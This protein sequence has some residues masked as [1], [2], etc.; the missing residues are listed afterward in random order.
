MSF[1]FV[2]LFSSGT[3]FCLHCSLIRIV[4]FLKIYN[5]FVIS[6]ISYM[7]A[8]LLFVLIIALSISVS[9]VCNTSVPI[10][11]KTTSLNLINC[12]DNILVSYEL[13]WY[14]DSGQFYFRFFSL[15]V[16]WNKVVCVNDGQIDFEIILWLRNAIFF[17]VPKYS[18]SIL[19]GHVF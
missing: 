16:T 7:E 13:S 9:L 12:S 3:I 2:H 1:S 6:E 5:I 14:F 8:Y 4:I 10:A 19:G 11:N 15:I 17:C 18:W